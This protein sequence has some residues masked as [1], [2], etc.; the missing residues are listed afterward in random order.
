MRF[1][2]YCT[3]CGNEVIGP[4][5]RTEAGLKEVQIL[6]LQMKL[7]CR[8]CDGPVVVEAVDDEGRHAEGS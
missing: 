4:P 2:M 5:G 7:R 1:R 6:T 3:G 8:L